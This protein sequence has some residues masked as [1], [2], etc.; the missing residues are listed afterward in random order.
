MPE[1]EQTKP[2]IKETEPPFTPF[3]DEQD[4]EPIKSDTIIKKDP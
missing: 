4:D 1:E 3:Q 2:E